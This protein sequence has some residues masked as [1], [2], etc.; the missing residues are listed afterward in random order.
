MTKNMTSVLVDKQ[1][2]PIDHDNL[3]FSSTSAAIM[4][5]RE[6]HAAINFETM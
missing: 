6:N 1:K 5:Y 4:T 2:S 3:L